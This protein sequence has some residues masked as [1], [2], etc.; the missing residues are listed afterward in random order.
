MSQ[1]WQLTDVERRKAVTSVVSALSAFIGPFGPLA[2]WGFDYLY[3]RRDLIFGTSGT[4][5]RAYTAT[6]TPLALLALTQRIN[7]PQSTV[8]IKPK[9]TDS[10]RDLGLCKGDPVS[11]VV[12]GHTA[13]QSRSG[14]VVPARIGERVAI[15]VPNGGYSLAAFGGKNTALFTTHDP[16]TVLTGRNVKLSESRDLSL[17]L[18]VRPQAVGP[19][20]PQPLRSD[21]CVWCA[22]P[23][24]GGQR[25][26]H[27]FICPAVPRN[28]TCHRCGALFSTNAQL[29]D[30]TRSAHPVGSLIDRV[31]DFFS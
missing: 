13:A 5:L 26:I 29:F 17:R 6:S 4:P 21:V 3:D 25:L 1:S 18:D 16:Y 27:N 11:L 10:A 23:I 30:H 28:F 19:S 8:S 14:L 24:P 15:T 7:G 2:M 12:T 9:L 22:K 31:D 20:K